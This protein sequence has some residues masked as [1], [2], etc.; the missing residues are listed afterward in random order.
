MSEVYS[1]EL[2]ELAIDE[3][4]ELGVYSSSRIYAGL[5][6]R[7]MNARRD[8]HVARSLAPMPSNEH[9]ARKQ[10]WRGIWVSTCLHFLHYNMA[11]GISEQP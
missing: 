4:R 10:S 1:R 7:V 5:A 6:D 11:A 2:Q 3:A 9:G 8:T